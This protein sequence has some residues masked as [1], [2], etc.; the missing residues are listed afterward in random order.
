MGGDVVGTEGSQCPVQ[1]AR[2]KEKREERRLFG[3][4]VKEE[5]S[6]ILDYQHP[7]REA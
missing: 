4:F 6:R 7:Q 1:T 2:R 5:Q 3:L